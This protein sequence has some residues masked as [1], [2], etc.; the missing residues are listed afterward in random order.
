[1][2]ENSDGEP[3][4]REAQPLTL[5]GLAAWVAFLLTVLGV[6]WIVWG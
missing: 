3:K 6:V 1:M 2:S 5:T 4:R